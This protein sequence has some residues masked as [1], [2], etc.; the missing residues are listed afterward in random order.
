[1]NVQVGL[2][3][4]EASSGSTLLHDLA[5]EQQLLGT[6]TQSPSA[7]SSESRNNSQGSLS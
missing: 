1:M 4:A 6:H 3:A 5:A 2:V 7:D